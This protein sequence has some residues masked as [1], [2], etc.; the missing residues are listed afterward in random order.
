MFLLSVRVGFT[1]PTTTHVVQRGE[2]FELIAQRY[3]ITKEELLQA[4]PEDEY[5]FVGMELRIPTM[6]STPS[7][8]VS[9]GLR[10]TLSQ[11][12]V[13]Y[14]NAST[15]L[16]RGKYSK[17][18]KLYSNIIDRRSSAMAYMGRGYSYYKRGKYKSAI[19][20][21]KS[22]S[23]QSD[24]TDEQREKIEEYLETVQKLRDE[25]IERRSN[26][27][28]GIA[29]VAVSAAATAAVVSSSNSNGSRYVAPSANINGFH[30]NTNMDYLLDPRYAMMQVQQEELAEYQQYKQL[31]GQD[32]TLEQYRMLKAMSASQNSSSD[33]NSQYYETS[34]YSDTSISYG[35]SVTRKECPACKGNRTIVRN[36]GSIS[37]YGSGGYMK[38]CPTCGAEYWSTTF[39]RHENCNVC[40][41]KGYV[42]Y[43]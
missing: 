39:H 41:G 29:T 38:K 1:H 8:V 2:N 23:R 14:K 37:S 33:S 40:H 25:Q 3:G 4:N 31:T 36:D 6:T 12:F 17:A 21:F 15:F 22:A 20:D 18:T 10:T 28:A 26:M 43:R 24:C 13:D 27:W 35:S 9:T 30:R 32:I 16:K 19:K 42:E 34:S 7:D 11:D 5:C